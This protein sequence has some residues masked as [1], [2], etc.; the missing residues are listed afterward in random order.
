MLKQEVVTIQLS[1]Y[2]R[3]GLLLEYNKLLTGVA[4]PVYYVCL[5]VL[6]CVCVCVCVC[7][8]ELTPTQESV[9]RLIQVR[10]SSQLLVKIGAR[11]TAECT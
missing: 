10:S 8:C 1:R 9:F 4:T 5:G 6:V 7:K 11:V 2:S 3:Q